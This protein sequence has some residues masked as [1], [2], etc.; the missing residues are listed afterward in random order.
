M[1]L[2]FSR[3]ARLCLAL[4]P[5][6][7]LLFMPRSAS[8]QYFEELEQGYTLKDVPESDALLETSP[9][10]EVLA[11]QDACP[12]GM[13]LSCIYE[14][15]SGSM[16][17]LE[18][19]WLADLDPF[20]AEQAMQPPADWAGHSITRE[21]VGYD[22]ALGQAYI[23]IG[24]HFEDDN[25]WGLGVVCSFLRD[26]SGGFELVGWHELGHEYIG[27]VFVLDANNDGLLDVIASWMTGAGSGGGVD[28]L[29]VN[30]DASFSYFGNPDDPDDFSSQ[31]WSAHGT[32]E[33]TDYDNDGDWEL[34]LT[35]PLFFSAAG[36]YYRDIVSF[37][38][39]QNAWAWDPD[40]APEYYEREDAFYRKLYEAVK[41]LVANPQQFHRESDDYYSSYMVEIDGEEYSLV[42]FINVDSGEPNADWVEDLRLFVEGQ[43]GKEDPVGH[44]FLEQVHAA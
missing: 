30:P 12:E 20:Y 22:T 17:V 42:P 43:E 41:R 14:L 16:R 39:Q 3:K 33:L 6:I 15:R 13:D 18:Q 31:L 34:Q 24:V 2:V 11:A 28:L 9:A 7:M 23:G 26:D 27:R 25:S 19:R 4:C 37:D 29:T 21:Q 5:L 32:V 44:W 10:P 35:Y 8:A 36:Y 1:T 38:P 40:F